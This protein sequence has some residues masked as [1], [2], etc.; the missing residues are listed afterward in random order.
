MGVFAST[1]DG[2]TTGQPHDEIRA[3]GLAVVVEER[4]LLGEIAVVEHAG[5]L[6]HAPQLHFPPTAAHVRLA[7]RLHEVARLLPQLHLCLCHLREL[8]ADLAVG[9]LAHALQ[10]VDLLVDLF[11]RILHRPH[12]RIDGLLTLFRDRPSLPAGIPPA[13]P[14]RGP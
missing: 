10:R 9:L 12:Q 3:D 7:K 13:R 11:Q 2:S 6:D 8:L 4:L 5:H 1:D 14:W